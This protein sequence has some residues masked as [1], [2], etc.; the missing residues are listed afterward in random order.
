MKHRGQQYLQKYDEL[1]RAVTEQAIK[2]GATILKMFGNS[3]TAVVQKRL[4]EPNCHS[5][6]Y[7]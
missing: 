4:Q 5:F 2:T 1:I 6:I 7:K 3:G